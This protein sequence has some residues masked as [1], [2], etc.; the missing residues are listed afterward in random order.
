MARTALWAPAHRV[1]QRAPYPGIAS[2]A[3]NAAPSLDA[4]GMGIQDARLP[5]NS[6]NSATGAQ[7][8][9]WYLAGPH[10]V[11]DAVPSTLSTVAISAA[12]VPTAG[13]PLVLVSSSGAGITVLS[14]SA[15]VLPSLNTIPSGT[16][17]IDSSPAVIRFGASDYTVFYDA[18]TSIA[19]NIQIR[20]VGDD[21]GATFLVSGYDLYGY[22]M[23]E[24]ITGS[25]GA[26]G[27]ATGK[28]AFKFVT[29]IVPAGTLS[30]SNVSVGQ[31]DTY[32]LPLLLNATTA[33]M[34]FWNNLIITGAGTATVAD[35]NAPTSVTGDVRGTYLV[36]SAS[37]GSKRL[38][39]YQ[40]PSVAQMQSLGL[41]T[42]VFGKT[43]A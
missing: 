26:P 24:R 2:P 19:R 1:L 15:L 33:L 32:G 30:G 14:S 25:S 16:L 35:T 11:I 27:T 7:A 40:H 41:I 13:T 43:Q 10:P 18:G 21:S 31:G 9:G 3:P 34:G 22:P 42:G 37:D 12:A 6:A 8:I 23:T 4:G 38:Q 36:G 39:V 28:K 5:W 20:S 17:V 29:S